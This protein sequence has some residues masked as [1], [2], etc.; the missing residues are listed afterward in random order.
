MASKRLT[1]GMKDEIINNMKR[2]LFKGRKDA[3]LKKKEQLGEEVYHHIYSKDDR[4]MMENAPEGAFGYRTHLDVR[5][6]GEGWY[7]S[8]D[9]AKARPVFAR[10]E[11]S[12]IKLPEGSPFKKKYLAINAEGELIK[13]EMK[14]LE[15]RANAIMASITTVKK[16]LE[17]W[18]EAEAY[19]PEEPPKVDNLPA[20]PVASLNE[21]IAQLAA[22]ANVEEVAA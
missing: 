22:K 12:S 21:M 5:F 6:H 18:P 11:R 8:I 1:Q 17:V 4:A 14:A 10:E 20:I 9:L 15:Q 3:V 19:L 7:E 13:D 16:L 2:Q